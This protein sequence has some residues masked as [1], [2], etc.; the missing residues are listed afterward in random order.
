VI[1]SGFPEQTSGDTDRRRRAAEY[2][3]TTTF[4]KTTAFVGELAALDRAM[5]ETGGSLKK[6][7]RMT[8]GD[9]VTG[10][11]LQEQF[12]PA[13]AK[14]CAFGIYSAAKQT[15]LPGTGSARRSAI[16]IPISPSRRR[17]ARR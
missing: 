4:E 9:D 5:L 1:Q 2:V 17:L 11:T 14:V 16:S 15:L 8:D 13:D 12:I 3:R 6:D 10:M 7:W